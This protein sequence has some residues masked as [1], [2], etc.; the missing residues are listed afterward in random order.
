MT[1]TLDLPRELEADLAVGA[2]R[3]GVPI[4]TY[5]LRLLAWNNH[6][7]GEPVPKAGSLRRC[8]FAPF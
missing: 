3:E 1:L 5:A 6:I 2:A 8:W 4:E 7:R